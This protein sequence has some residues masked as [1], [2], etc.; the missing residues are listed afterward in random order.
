MHADREWN[1]PTTTDTTEQRELSRVAPALLTAALGLALI[2]IAGFAES[3]VLHNA[4]HDT[5]HSTGFP[6][7]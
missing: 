7:H 1:T 3:H 2:F 5:R 4:G 6:C